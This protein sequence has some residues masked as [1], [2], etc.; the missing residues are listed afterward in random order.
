MTKQESLELVRV[1]C[2]A[3]RDTKAETLDVIEI[4]EVSSVADYFVIAS[5]TNVRQM[6]AMV[7]AVEE[8]CMKAGFT[9]DHI[10]GHRNTN[11][12]LMDYLGVVIHVFDEEAR[13]FYDLAR[14]WKDGKTLDPD[15]LEEAAKDSE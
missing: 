14:M 2:E 1:A 12:T 8:K 9:L 3:L 4:D 5:G 7:D 11:W 6:E 13:G 15:T 10:E